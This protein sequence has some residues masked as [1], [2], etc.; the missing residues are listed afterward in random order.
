MEQTEKEWEAKAARLYRMQAEVS[1]TSVTVLNPGGV[2][3][4]AHT[5][6]GGRPPPPP[7]PRPPPPPPPPRPAPFLPIL[8]P[9]R[10][11]LQ[12]ETA[13]GQLDARRKELEAAERALALADATLRRRAEELTLGEERLR[14]AAAEADRAQS[15]RELTDKV[16]HLW[17]LWYLWH[18]WPM[19]AGMGG[20]GGSG[21]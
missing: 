12:V 21:W 4:L 11:A 8:D 15:R 17:H 3:V 2:L 5:A 19:A 18:L 6:G 16:W 20:L 7:P 13:G 14:I 9:I 1:G 10:C